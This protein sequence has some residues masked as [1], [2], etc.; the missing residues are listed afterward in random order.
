MN[1]SSSECGVNFTKKLNLL[2]LNF[3]RGRDLLI[4]RLVGHLLSFPHLAFAW[5]P[6]VT[7]HAHTGV[8]APQGF[9]SLQARQ[10]L[11]TQ[12]SGGSVRDE[13]PRT[14]NHQGVTVGEKSGT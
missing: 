13:E 1:G 9:S 6:L 5:L 4:R 11:Q 14:I 12:L 7:P 10:F 8:P 2:V 3:S